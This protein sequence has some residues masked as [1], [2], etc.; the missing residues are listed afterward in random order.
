MHRENTV[1][2]EIATRHNLKGGGKSEV[3]QCVRQVNLEPGESLGNGMFLLLHISHCL[4]L[5]LAH[6]ACT[7]FFVACGSAL[8][9]LRDMG[10]H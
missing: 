9:A 8:R 6:T 10:A 1:T 5:I 7:L 4:L 3:V 2:V